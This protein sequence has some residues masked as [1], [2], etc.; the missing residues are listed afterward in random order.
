M[1]KMCKFE[2]VQF[3]ACHTGAR[4][5][6]RQ[7]GDGFDAPGEAATVVASVPIA[8]NCLGASL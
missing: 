4:G 5:V 7:S 1:L 2:T 3:G 6:V 8:L